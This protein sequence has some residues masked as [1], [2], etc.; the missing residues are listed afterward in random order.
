LFSPDGKT[1]ATTYDLFGLRLIDVA[2][3]K[4]QP[5]FQDF[6]MSLRGVAFSPKGDLLA[7]ADQATVRIWDTKSEKLVRILLG[8][9]GRQQEVSFSP[10]GGALAVVGGHVTLWDV[11]TGKKITTLKAADDYLDS[12]AFHPNGKYLATTGAALN[13]EKRL[14]IWNYVAGLEVTSEKRELQFR[15]GPVAYGPEGK[16]L[17]FAERKRFEGDS[18]VVIWETITRKERTVLKGHTSFIRSVAM[19]HDGSLLASCGDDSLIK[20]WETATGK[21]LYTLKGHE[22]QIHTVCFSP[23][24]L[25]LASGGRDKTVR[26]WNLKEGKEIAALRGHS[27]QVVSVRFSPDG[28]TL[29]SGSFDATVKLWGVPAQKKE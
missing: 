12:L 16:F 23:D 19:N 4:D 17:A 10:D 7:S 2:T 26:V 11:S 25:L 13:G 22:G 8:H 9:D 15:L 1:L 27:D 5:P 28:R 29:A 18:Q 14:R 3:G 6:S 20:V 21:E 24:G